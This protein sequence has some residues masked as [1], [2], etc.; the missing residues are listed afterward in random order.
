MSNLVLAKNLTTKTQQVCIGLDDGVADILEM[1]TP[2]T[3]EILVSNRL[4][5][6]APV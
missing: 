1:V 5:P 6:D 2:T 4:L 3:A